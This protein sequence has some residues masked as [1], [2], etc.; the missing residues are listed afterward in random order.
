MEIPDLKGRS[1]LDIGCGSG[2]HSLAAL[3]AGAAKVISFD[4]DP[5]S[6]E[7]TRRVRE[8]SGSP[9]TWDVLSGSI[10]DE[11]FLSGISLAD[12]VYSWG[13]LHHTGNMWKAVE[14][15]SRFIKDN[16]IFY[17][18]LYVTTPKS[19]YWVRIKKRYNTASSAGKAFMEQWYMW[20]HL[21][22]P[23]FMRSKDPLKYILEY[24]QKRG[25]SYFTDVKDWLG[26]YPYEH[27]KIE[28]VLKF[29]RE[30]LG[31]ELAGLGTGE[32]C[33]EYLFKK[34]GKRS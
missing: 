6:V 32:A 15:A 30:K 3:K 34:S 14:N 18:A 28:E 33:I 8:M 21:I 10:L 20:R 22:I 5:Y 13:V 16:G 24:K 4:V 12:I 26:G 2:I 17:V 27:A 23:Y 31:L 29:C 19:D 9:E 7:T 11:K 1:F 25:M